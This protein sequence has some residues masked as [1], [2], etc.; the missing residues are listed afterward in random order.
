M[1]ICLTTL[2]LLIITPS[3]MA[4]D[5]IGKVYHFT[6]DVRNIVWESS[7]I[8]T[9]FRL[10]EKETDK[11]VSYMALDQELAEYAN[12]RMKAPSTNDDEPCDDSNESDASKKGL[13]KK[14]E[15]RKY[16][17]YFTMTFND[18]EAVGLAEG[19]MGRNNFRTFM[20][21]KGSNG[22]PKAYGILNLAQLKSKFK[23]KNPSVDLSNLS[24]LDRESALIKFAED[25]SSIKIPKGMLL[26]EL[27]IDHAIKNPKDWKSGMAE[28]KD[29]LSFDQK[30]LVASSLGGKFS[31]R[32]NYDR[33][34]SKGE[35]VVTIEEMLESVRDG[36]PGGICRDVSMAQSAILKELGVPKDKIY[37]IGYSTS[38]GGHAVVAIQDPDNPKNIVKL[39][40][41]YVSE[42]DGAVGSS[43]LIQNTSLPD[44]G[45]QNRVY[46]ADG[47]PVAS[48]PTEIGE[49]LY[50]ATGGTK[51]KLAPPSRHSLSKVHVDTPFGSGQMFTGQTSSG[52]KVVGVA[53]T[54]TRDSKYTTDEVSIAGVQ[55][56]GD[57]SNS[58]ISQE[59]LYLRFK[60]T[61]NGPSLERENFSLSSRAGV[62]SEVF[63]MRNKVESSSKSK[64]DTNIDTTFKP[65]LGATAKWSVSE[66]TTV[67]SD[68]NIEGQLS[69]KNIQLKSTEGM[70][71]AFNKATIR[72]GI[73]HKVTPSMTVMGQSGIVL[74]Q[75]GNSASFSTGVIKETRKSDF[76]AI[77]TYSTPLSKDAPAFLPEAQRNFGVSLGENHKRSGLYYQFEYNRD[78]DNK[79]NS[80]GFG[81]GWKF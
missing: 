4:Q 40:Y 12:S 24:F 51:G 15:D 54:R 2:L 8:Q 47:V 11:A 63:L 71:L 37:Q 67:A 10:G 64:N 74:R 72:T 27:A 57:R 55:R 6:E 23:T 58:K 48:L 18:A 7:P 56:T 46:D 38:G 66:E 36:N 78:L 39:N 33:V 16:N 42:S 31:D 70:T 53:V 21:N 22:K 35:G 59:A 73:T 5:N 45:I 76:R 1:K 79:S 32:Y 29:E 49:V 28:I 14:I 26:S 20:L 52:D 68:I 61:L 80:I 44:F 3:L 19:F 62:E 77:A 41:G 34:G 17:L 9:D 75:I 69:N 43:A 13:A 81:G 65:F 25:Y 60:S 50:D 30:V